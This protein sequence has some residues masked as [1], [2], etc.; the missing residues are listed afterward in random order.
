MDDF[1]NFSRDQT[2]EA[3]KPE[4]PVPSCVS[5][6]S[7]RSMDDFPNFSS[8]QKPKTDTYRPPSPVPSCVSAESTHSIGDF[9]NFSRK[10][11]PSANKTETHRPPSL[12]PG[13][14]SVK[15]DRSMD[16][17]PNFS[18]EPAQNLTQDQCSC[19]QVG[20]GITPSGHLD[21][22]DNDLTLARKEYKT[23][24]EGRRRLLPAITC[25]KKAR[26]AECT[27]TEK[28]CGIVAAALQTPNFLVQLDLSGNN[29]GDCGVH[30]L[31]KGLSSS[32]CRLDL[33]RLC[34]C[35][36]S[37]EGYVCLALTLM[38][39]PS[40]VKEL[41]FSNNHP[42]ETAQ[43]LLVSTLENPHY[44]VEALQLADCKLTDKSCEIVASVLQSINSL[45]Q[46]DLSD[47]VLGDS[48]V[49]LLSKGLSSP[50]CRLNT[51]RL[52]D[53]LISEKGCVCLASA[54]TS[55]PAH[56]KELDLSYNHPQ[57]S[58]LKLLR[59]KVEDPG[60][61][62]EALNSDHVLESRAGQRLQ[63]Y[64][65][66]LSPKLMG[67]TV[68][69]MAN[70]SDMPVRVYYRKKKMQLEEMVEDAGD[71][72]DGFGTGNVSQSASLFFRSDS[73][74]RYVRI[75]GKDYD[76]IVKRGPFYVCIFLEGGNHNEC[77]RKIA[78]R[79]VPNNRSFIV[80]KKL[81]FEWQRY[82]ANIW[83]DEQG[84]NH[85]PHRK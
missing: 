85:Y 21:K 50:N 80:T 67:S 23:S 43:T 51:L 60:S 15:S 72:R 48:G 47:N 77:V 83:E 81:N 27:L 7:G 66:G 49:Q 74:I 73:R 56:L 36:V 57:E 32:Q 84:T 16:D 24:D 59:A 30:L 28:S 22:Q 8:G 68:T 65:W 9:P 71:S 38:L 34:N 19:E 62:L 53:C 13:C 20:P 29:L 26:L 44:Q 35:S 58:G 39:N 42:A 82:G 52:S 3:V 11:K 64:A 14:V 10:P 1:P 17:F 69:H 78:E 45:L 18:R 54:L 70:A 25:F 5:V 12:V 61:R 63:R 6:K 4:S 46:M 75:P 41:D 76:K 31:C 40:C 55:N 79:S 37:D 2:P 33:L